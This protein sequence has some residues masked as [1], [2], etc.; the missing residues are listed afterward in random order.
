MNITVRPKSVASDNPSLRDM[1]KGKGDV[2]LS[3]EGM[4]PKLNV[5]VVSYST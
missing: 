2:T 1:T 4:S 3:P 5:W